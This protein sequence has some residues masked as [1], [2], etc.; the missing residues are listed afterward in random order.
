MLNG[1]R[2]WVIADFDLTAEERAAILGVRAGTLQD[3]SR[4]LWDWAS[5]REE[6]GPGPA[7]R[8]M[9]DPAAF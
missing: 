5:A 7:G 1:S 6:E 3:F 8:G 4:A 9:D 2:K